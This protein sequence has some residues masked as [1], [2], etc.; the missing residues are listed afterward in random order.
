M[1]V[2]DQIT[3]P[4]SWLRTLN[5]RTAI[6]VQKATEAIPTTATVEHATKP[7]QQV[8]LTENG[9]KL[10]CKMNAACYQEVLA[11]VLDVHATKK[12]ETEGQEFVLDLSDVEQLDLTGIFAL[13]CI[14]MVMRGET[15]PDPANGWSTLRTAA[16]RNLAA[17]RQENLK[18][19]NPSAPIEALLRANHFDRVLIIE[20]QSNPNQQFS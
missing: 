4:F 17:G 10:P 5:S 9:I 18:V 14:A 8:Q 2:F 19:S 20:S 16:E 7:A 6:V 12:E 3:R 11:V 15:I 1:T 13:H